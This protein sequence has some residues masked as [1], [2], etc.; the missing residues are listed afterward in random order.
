MAPVRKTVSVHEKTVQKVAKQKIELPKRKRKSPRKRNSPVMV[1]QILI[2]PESV[3]EL[4]VQHV[5]M[6]GIDPSRIEI[7]SPD[8]IVIH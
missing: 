2:W 8:E 4:I 3:N 1:I 6:E 5:E 7:V